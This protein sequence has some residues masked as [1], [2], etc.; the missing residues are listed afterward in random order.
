MEGEM[1]KSVLGLMAWFAISVVLP[2]GTE[3]TAQQPDPSQDPNLKLLFDMMRETKIR[4]AETAARST[5]AGAFVHQR[6]QA[7]NWQQKSLNGIIQYAPPNFS[8]D[9]SCVVQV[10]P[11]HQGGGVETFTVSRSRIAEQIRMSIPGPEFHQRNMRDGTVLLSSMLGGSGYLI[12]D[13]YIAYKG[14]TE[15]LF[16]VYDPNVGSM[17]SDCSYASSTVISIG[18]GE[19]NSS[20]SYERDEE[21]VEEAMNIIRSKCR[22]QCDIWTSC[23]DRSTYPGYSSRQSCIEQCKARC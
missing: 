14:G 4:E 8:P 7:A 11:P 2:L 10:A 6:L 16:I 20:E 23:S 22:M 1:K 13:M 3:V 5:Q 19:I 12:A 17:N 9:Q 21:A 15:Q 18:G